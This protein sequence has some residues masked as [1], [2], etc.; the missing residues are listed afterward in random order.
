M[1]GGK[2]KGSKRRYKSMCHSPLLA[3]MLEHSHLLQGVVLQ[4]G[5]EGGLT[6]CIGKAGSRWGQ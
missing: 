2:K 4:P 3:A 1:K 5:Q 6:K